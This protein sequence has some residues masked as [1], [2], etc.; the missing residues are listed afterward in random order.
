MRADGV[1]KGL[2]SAAGAKE[3]GL[4]PV[5]GAVSRGGHNP[6]TLDAENVVWVRVLNL[7][8]VTI[9]MTLRRHARTVEGQNGRRTIHSHTTR[10]RGSGG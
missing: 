10:C 5:V 4:F 9:G 3:P 2:E 1:G 7:P 8:L 6:G